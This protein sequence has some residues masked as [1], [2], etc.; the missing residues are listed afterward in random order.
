VSDSGEGRWTIHA[1]IDEAV[2][3]PVLT[4]AL[5]QRFSSRGASDY[6]DKVLSA[7]RY[8]FGGHAELP[9]GH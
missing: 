9:R 4:T 5:Y 3:A 8:A 1:A 7:M 6:A 2:P